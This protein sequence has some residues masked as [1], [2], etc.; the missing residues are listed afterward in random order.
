MRTTGSWPQAARS[1]SRDYFQERQDLT[2]AVAADHLADIADL[3]NQEIQQMSHEEL[4]G[5]VD[6]ARP[7]FLNERCPNRLSHFD[8]ATLERLAYLARFCCQNRRARTQF[9]GNE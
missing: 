6:A 2:V 5:V 7:L 4:V 3:K 8:Q 1:A 9:S